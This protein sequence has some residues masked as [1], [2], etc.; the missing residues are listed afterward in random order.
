MFDKKTLENHL[1]F[2]YFC[3]IICSIKGIEQNDF[4]DPFL[5]EVWVCSL[6]MH[7]YRCLLSLLN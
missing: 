2:P 3:R 5:K 7:Y 4:C 1:N 6:E